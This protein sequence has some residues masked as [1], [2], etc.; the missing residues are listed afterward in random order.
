MGKLDQLRQLGAKHVAE[1][2]GAARADGLPPGLDLQQAAGMPARLVGLT[3]EKGAARIPV[4]RIERDPHQPREDFDEE[5]LT[6][7]A[8]SLRS[9]G[10][11]QPIRVRWDEG[12]GSYI[13][14]LGERRWRAAKMAGLAELSCIIHD[15]DLGPVD[16]LGLQLVENALREDLKPIEQARAYKQVMEA[17]SWSTRQLA[18][19][20]QI[21]QTSVVRALTLL[22]LPAVVQDQVEQGGLPATTAAEIAKLDRPEDQVAVAQVAV[23]QGL[24]R[25]ELVEIVKAVRARKP[26][27]APRPDPVTMDLG[28]GMT[29]KLT[30]RKTNGID[31]V[32]ALRRALK[33]AQEQAQADH[34]A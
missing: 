4:D 29:L 10:Q 16:R 25:H 14:L 33:L 19:E 23:E 21:S 34:A 26:A 13:V 18:D 5:S 6:R 17:R 3:K 1:S 11:L 20:L 24:G 8:E 22:E 12:K 31:L 2:T 27:P 9:K 30:W 7:L 15:G 32:K 28:N